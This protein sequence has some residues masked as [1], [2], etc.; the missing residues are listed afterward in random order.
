MNFLKLLTFS[1]ILISC[2]GV[3]YVQVINTDSD[4]SKNYES[5]Y[6]FENDSVKIA[7]SFWNE[8]GLVSFSIFNKMNI[9]IYI[10]WKKSSYI[11]N[12]VKLNYWVD[13]QIEKSVSSYRTYYYNGP[14]LA[15]GY[16]VGAIA[17]ATVSSTSKAERV[18]FIPPKSN[19]YRSQFYI[20][21][22]KS[23]KL[24]TTTSFEEV[25]LRSKPKKMTK[26]YSSYY[27]RENSPLTFRNFLTFSVSE[28]FETEFYVDNM[29]Y[30]A[31]VLEMDVRHFEQYRFDETQ[32]V[33]LFIRDE[34][35]EPILFTDFK[36]HDSFYKRIP[37]DISIENRK[38]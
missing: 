29:F 21:P 5:F 18:T 33:M 35:G 16:G 7:Y 6:L 28:N 38:K 13:E 36:K 26:I 14:L 11:D 9:P 19:Y 31:E 15:P 20:L 17:G 23:V 1:F 2:K 25:P 8:S 34:Y 32:K 22:V 4:I 37:K 27:S 3:S 24:K 30:I 12:S 10:D